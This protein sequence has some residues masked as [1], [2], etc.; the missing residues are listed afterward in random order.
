[1]VFYTGRQFPSEY[2]GEVFAALHGSWNRA[3]RTGFKVVRVLLKGGGPTGEYEDF[4]TGFLTDGGEI[5]GRPVGVAVSK[6]GALY[7]SDDG[8]NIIWRVSYVGR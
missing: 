3:K 7:V 6:D 2:D 4:M 5:W 8:S 1:M